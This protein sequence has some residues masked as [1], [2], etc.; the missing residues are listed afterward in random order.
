[1][2][3][4]KKNNLKFALSFIYVTWCK[5]LWRL[6]T[7]PKLIFLFLLYL[8]WL[9]L[10]TDSQLKMLRSTTVKITAGRRSFI[11]LSPLVIEIDNSNYSCVLGLKEH[12]A[13]IYE[14]SKCSRVVTVKF[15]NYIRLSIPVKELYITAKL[16]QNM[17]GS[18]ELEYVT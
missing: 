4:M 16:S 9:K 10:R 6:C 13:F 1:M 17:D 11:V 18:S 14:K 15:Y 2:Y 8:L 5:L 12:R 3:L 7:R